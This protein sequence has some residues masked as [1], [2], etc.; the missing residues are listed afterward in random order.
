VDQVL[1]GPWQP[2]PFSEIDDLCPQSY[3]SMNKNYNNNNN[4]KDHAAYY[5]LRCDGQ[6]VKTTSLVC[7]VAYV[8]LTFQSS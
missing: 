3:V 7:G 4:S 1:R 5:T 8:Y 2:S 6:V